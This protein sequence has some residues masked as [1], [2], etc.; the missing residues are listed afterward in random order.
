METDGAET[1]DLT[2]DVLLLQESAS[3]NAF[4]SCT[5]DREE[6]T[7]EI[8]DDA[9]P[10]FV[11][12]ELQR[13]YSH[14]FSSLLQFKVYGQMEGKVSTYIVR[15]K[16][17]IVTLYLFRRQHGVVTVL[18]ESIPVP[19]EDADRFARHVFE[20][21]AG[22]RQVCFHAVLAQPSPRRL[23]FAQQQ[24][25]CAEDIVIALPANCNDYLA[26]LGKN[27]R[28]NIRR[29]M[30][31]LLKNFPS[32]R[33]D[34]MEGA[35]IGD[36]ALRE[37][38]AFNRAR[39]AGKNKTSTLDDVE[40]ERI[41]CIA[42]ECGL[43][44]VARI[45]GRIRAGGIAYRVG[46]NFFLYVIAH[47]PAYND[48]W[49]GILT[50]YLTICECIARGGKKFHF[51]WGRYDYKFALGSALH[52]LEHR[53]IYRSRAAM[54]LNGVAVA[55]IAA[56]KRVNALKLALLDGARRQDSMAFKIVSRL[57]KAKRSIDGLRGAGNGGSGSRA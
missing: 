46:D 3:K 30:E 29:Y 28:R 35:A 16:G 43:I 22:V 32:F 55:R 15:R 14:I 56:G 31:R 33:C 20:R 40:A 37:I 11:E 19:D 47:D 27:T 41:L 53:D 50:C 6:I 24:Y 13:L 48:Y 45:D 10:S 25:N 42:R 18:N 12:T 39:M 21:Y 1:K 52:E 51:L 38:I 34:F 23:V 54:L 36:E 2:T 57:R 49:L 8:R 5:N 7:V 9:V 17:E 44:S 26:S 4:A